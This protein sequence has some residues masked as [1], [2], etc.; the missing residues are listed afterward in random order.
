MSKQFTLTAIDRQTKEI[1]VYDGYIENH[2]D[3]V[4]VYYRFVNIV[5]G[6][7]DYMSFFLSK[8][9]CENKSEYN[10]TA[11]MQNFIQGGGIG[12]HFMIKASIKHVF[13]L[14]PH[15]G[16]IKVHDHVTDDQIFITPKRLLLQEPGWYEEYFGAE[17]TGSNMLAVHAFM[18]DLRE[19]NKSLEDMIRIVTQEN[20]GRFDDYRDE[21]SHLLGS[22]WD[23]RRRTADGYDV[24]IEATDNGE[25]VE[26]KW[27]SECRNIENRSPDYGSHYYHWYH[28]RREMR[29]RRRNMEQ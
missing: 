11:L 12:N 29:E 4:R 6:V 27:Y 23:I 17:A 26:P 28:K 13:S 19:W 7:P 2:D 8:K 3:C 25:T 22:R 5:T 14:F 10:D 24:E 16:K 15:L 20:W 18:L 21:F 9:E 1:F